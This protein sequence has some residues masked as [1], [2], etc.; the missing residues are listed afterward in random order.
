MFFFV[1]SKKPARPPPPRPATGP[2]IVPDVDEEFA[3]E[4][5]DPFDTGFVE[6]VL[7]ATAK[8]DDDFDP[9][10][11]SNFNQEEDDDFNF[12]PRA[13]EDSSVV[14]TRVKTPD[15][16]SAEE[17]STL[18]VA[19][20]PAKDLL[21]GSCADLTNISQTPLEVA[22]VEG[23]S[24]DF[25]DPFDTSAVNLIVAP[26]KTELKFLEKEFLSDGLKHSLSDPDFDPRAES[27]PEPKEQDD[28]DSIVQRKSSLSLHIN[29]ATA[30]SKTVLFAVPTPDLLK[31]DGDHSV[32]KKPLTPYY[33]R[34]SSLPES[35]T[36]DPFDTTFVPSIVPSQLEL[37]LIEKELNNTVS[38]KHSLSDQDFDPRADSAAEEPKP[39]PPKSDLLGTDD[40]FNQKV[41]TP[42]QELEPEDI[43]P[44]DTSI[45]I[46]IQ[47]G[48]AELRLLENEFNSEVPTVVG[49]QDFLS[50]SQDSDPFFVKV[51]TPQ[52]NNST[53]EAD[54]DPFDTSFAIDL[55]PGRT[56][57][58]LLESELIDRKY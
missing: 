27:E 32:T 33:S 11:E 41:L 28:F 44:F 23:E 10:A 8:E 6:R 2:R 7:P 26:G 12:D 14:P 18:Q 51:L 38:I 19:S 13:E 43:D 1:V 21:S 9:R 4:A 22:A 3:L 58:K 34:E 47:P 31:I 29:T 57:I 39:A 37:N 24:E 50:G 56:E 48:R 20:L 36:V 55:G 42:A 17:H 45:A 5:D 52:L 30:K 53:E 15:L 49:S 35:D 40:N 25:V 16:F 46:N 54:I